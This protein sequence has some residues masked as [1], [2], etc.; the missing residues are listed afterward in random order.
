MDID[1]SP[2]KPPPPPGLQ[3]TTPPRKK[4]AP[5]PAIP[6]TTP[7]SPDLLSSSH[8]PSIENALRPRLSRTLTKR[9]NT[10]AD[11]NQQNS[12]PIRLRPSPN[13]DTASKLQQARILM[14]EVYHIPGIDKQEAGQALSAIDSIRRACGYPHLG[15]SRDPW[16]NPSQPSNPKA[17]QEELN[18]LRQELDQKFTTLANLVTNNTTHTGTTYAD[19]V[20]QS[21]GPQQ[22]PTHPQTTPK[23]P[24]AKKRQPTKQQK[25]PTSTTTGTN[26]K[27]I[28]LQPKTEIDPATWRPIHF[29]D[30]FNLRL[31][32]GGLDQRIGAAAFSLSRSGNIVVTAKEGCTADDLI[33]CKELWMTEA[34]MGF[35]KDEK[36]AKVIAHGVPA[37]AFGEDMDAMHEEITN[38]NDNIHLAAPPRWLTKKETRE[39]KLHSSIL[40]CFKT[41]EEADGV[42]KKGL[43]I[44][45]VQTKCAAYRETQPNSQCN[46]CQGYGHHSNVCRKKTKCQLCAGDHNTRQHKCNTCQTIG[47]EC[48]HTVLRCTNCQGPHKANTPTCQT[49]IDINKASRAN[50]KPNPTTATPPTPS[51][52]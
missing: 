20:M 48:S 14:E 51:S 32:Q 25:D 43:L 52:D 22:Q 45:A 13:A 12:Q 31:R 41:K 39:G 1:T 6:I 27:R 33:G 36:W 7:S 38:Y 17:I 19:A 2:S 10:Q 23:P 44:G 18:N 15:S 34:V 46:H 35:R 4:Q 30:A 29:R 40:L 26:Q 47:K 21:A 16:N 49:F 24:P 8:A 5:A 50:T 9:T 42:I 3:T 11:P 37:Y 28:I